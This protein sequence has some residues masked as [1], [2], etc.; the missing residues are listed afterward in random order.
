MA[1]TAKNSPDSYGGKLEQP[2]TFTG[3]VEDVMAELKKKKI[4]L[5]NTEPANIIL[6]GHSGAFRVIAKILQNGGMTVREVV[7]FD[8]LYS[9]TDLFDT[10]IKK[11]PMNRFINW[12]TNE[13]GGTD[14]ESI[15]FM[16]QLKNEGLSYN[17]TEEKDLT[18]AILKANRILFVHAPRPHNDI[19]F[20]P[21]NFL[22][23]LDNSPY[24][25]P[26]H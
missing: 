16:G 6:A 15:K 7:L 21:D 25:S 24:L 23:V 11:D 9:Q 20:N 5:E 22:L 13:G 12:Y 3:L 14:E 19:I 2:G 1:E 26:L 4:I 8:A 18:P 10:W 17:L